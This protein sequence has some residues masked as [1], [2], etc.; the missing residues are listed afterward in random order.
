MLYHLIIKHNIFQGKHCDV[1]ECT[2][3]QCHNNGTCHLGECLCNGTGYYGSSCQKKINECESVPCQHNG[4]CQDLHKDYKCL[5]Q[6]PYAGA[7]CELSQ[8]TTT[9]EPLAIVGFTDDERSTTYSPEPA[10]KKRVRQVDYSY[11]N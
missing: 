6:Y 7:N 1:D 3:R 11:Y 4:E 5:C 2:I 8:T 10:P 9:C